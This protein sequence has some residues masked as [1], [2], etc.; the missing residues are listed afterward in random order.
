MKP[1]KRRVVDLLFPACEPGEIK[2]IIMDVGD[3]QERA[4]AAG[5]RWIGGLWFAYPR[6][7][8]VNNRGD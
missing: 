7:K 4:L 6:N 3:R 8:L 2:R 5:W 1:L